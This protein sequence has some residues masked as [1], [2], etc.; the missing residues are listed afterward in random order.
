MTRDEI[1]AKLRSIFR[2]HLGVSPAVT[3]ALVPQSVSAGKLY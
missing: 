1:Q 3:Q 2:R